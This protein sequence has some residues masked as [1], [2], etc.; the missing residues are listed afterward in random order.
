MH[1]KINQI[2]IGGTF[3]ILI[4]IQAHSLRRPELFCNFR[5]TLFFT[6]FNCI[7]PKNVQQ[8]LNQEKPVVSSKLKSGCYFQTPVLGG[9]K[10]ANVTKWVS[11]IKHCLICVHF[12]IKPDEGLT[13]RLLW[14]HSTYCFCWLLT[15]NYSRFKVSVGLYNTTLAQLLMLFLLI[16][17]QM[18]ITACARESM[19]LWDLIKLQWAN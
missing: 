9:G 17:I 16:E 4:E 3:Y 14:S 7:I 11:T 8:C 10:L 2:Q 18:I 5:Q 13:V 19:R 1:E 12:C 15:T 6:F